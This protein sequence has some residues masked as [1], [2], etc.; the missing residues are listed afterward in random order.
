MKEDFLRFGSKG[1]SFRLVLL[2]GW[3]ADADDLIPIGQELIRCDG[4]SFELISLS[5]PHPHP[6]G[7][8][9]QW[10]GLFP[11]AWDSVPSEEHELQD[12]LK[13]IASEEIPLS[14]TVLFGFSQ[15]AAMALATGCRLPFA[16]IIAC[17]AYPHPDWKPPMKTPPILLL[18][19]KND[20]IVP[21]MASFKLKEQFTKNQSKTEL[22]SFDGGHEIPKTLIGKMRLTLQDWLI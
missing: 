13:A 16:G 3:G 5:A 2:H 20:E 1:A 11:P 14:K 19:G 9:R 8:G 6:A 17:S 10:Y 12:R 7:T 18:H 22:I 4:R 21:I 15:G